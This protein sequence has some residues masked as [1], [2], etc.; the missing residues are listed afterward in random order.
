M[1]VANIVC[2]EFFL[3]WST[4]WHANLSCGAMTIC[5]T[6]V[7]WSNIRFVTIHALISVWSKKKPKNPKYK[8]TILAIL[9]ASKMYFFKMGDRWGKCMKNQL[10]CI[11]CLQVYREVWQCFDT[12]MLGLFCYYDNDKHCIAGLLSLWTVE[13]LTLAIHTSSQAAGCNVSKYEK[14]IWGKLI[15]REIDVFRRKTDV[16]QNSTFHGD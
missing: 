13:R 14:S 4:T 5:F 12:L 15:G 3:M 6:F 8:G 16:V 10:F 11:F 7:M 2:G 9:G 1:F